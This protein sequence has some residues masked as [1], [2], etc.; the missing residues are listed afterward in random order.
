[1]PPKGKLADSDIAILER[2]VAMGAPDPRTEAAPAKPIQPALEAGRAHW[3]FQPIATPPVPPVKDLTWPRSDIDRFILAKL[4]SEGL[5]PVSDA[6]RTTLLRR[7]FF[8]LVGIPP[9]PA[10]VA[11]FLAD[12]VPESLA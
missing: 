9:T 3:A 6:D 2:W 11:S 1:M 12:D 7:V 5:R 8:D 4:E 10:D